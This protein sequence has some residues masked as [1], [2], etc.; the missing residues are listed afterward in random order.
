MGGKTVRFTDGAEE[1]VDT[2]IYATGYKLKFPYFDSEKDRLI[3]H[4]ENENRGVFFGP[5]YKKFISIR[6]PD[7][8]FI[9]YLETTLVVNILPEL[10][11]LTA[12]YIIEGKL[13]VPSQ[14]EM[15]KDHNEEVESH[16]TH[17]GSLALFYKTDLSLKFPSLPNNYEHNEWLFFS[18]WLKTVHPDNNDPKAEEFFNIIADTKKALMKF[19]AE[20]N[21]LQYKKFDYHQIYPK[22][23]R[24]T[25]DFV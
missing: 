10:Q 13:Q 12:K 9:G 4:D 2:V 24:N 21:F 16:K 11:A 20:G 25:S 19:K 7:L 5:L 8:F 3:D 6:E 22:D 15:Y 18:N 23:F 14:E 17:I 1:E